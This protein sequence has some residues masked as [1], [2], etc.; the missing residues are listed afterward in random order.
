M[1]CRQRL[2][3][4]TR[5]HSGHA[6]L[7][8]HS[9]T[10]AGCF[11]RGALI[12][13]SFQKSNSRQRNFLREAEG[14]SDSLH[15]VMEKDSLQ[16]QQQQQQLLLSVTEDER[17]LTVSWLLDC[18]LDKKRYSLSVFLSAVHILDSFLGRCRINRTQLQISAVACAALAS[19][20]QRQQNVVDV[21][22][23][24]RYLALASDGVVPLKDV[25]VSFCSIL[26]P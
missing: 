16:V 10:L 9:L 25:G 17:N 4:E 22:D 2:L 1:H 5:S 20:R 8:L 26:S 12:G 18:F 21:D 3:S 13:T 24:V 14:K 11:V 23:L 15:S 19:K 7:L 6:R